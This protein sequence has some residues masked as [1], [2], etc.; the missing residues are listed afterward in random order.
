M[1]VCFVNDSFDMG[2]VQRVV[3]EIANALQRKGHKITL[4]DFSGNNSFFYRVD[5]NISKPNAITS[6]SL[7][8][9]IITKFIY[10]K[11]VL[12]KRDNSVLALYGEQIKSLINYLTKKDFDVLIMNQGTLTAVIPT[13]KKV[14]PNLKIVAWQHSEYN[15][16]IKK[17]NTAILNDYLLGAKQADLLIC[18]TNTDEKICTTK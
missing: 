11:N 2:G 9:K 14:L 10:K 3:I 18:L 17:Y 6:L 15:T 13:I 5:N 16:Y 4:I 12:L 1:N 7:N 8:K